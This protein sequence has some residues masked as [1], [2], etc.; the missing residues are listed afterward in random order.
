MKSIVSMGFQF[1][2]VNENKQMPKIQIDK[3]KIIS[4]VQINIFHMQIS[5]FRFQYIRGKKT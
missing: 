2:T 4:G 1:S 3:K 5:K